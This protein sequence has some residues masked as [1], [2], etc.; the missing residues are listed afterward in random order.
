MREIYGFGEQTHPY[1][2]RIATVANPVVTAGIDRSL[3]HAAE[4]TEDVKSMRLDTRENQ[5][6]IPLCP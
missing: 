1:V 2:G 4:N 3:Q 6:P 5:V